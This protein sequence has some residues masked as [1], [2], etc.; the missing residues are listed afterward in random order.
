MEVLVIR[1]TLAK[2][3]WEKHLMKAEC[4]CN[5]DR[6]QQRTDGNDEIVF[7]HNLLEEHESVE[8][9]T[10]TFGQSGEILDNKTLIPV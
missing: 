8:Y 1:H 4:L 3:E 10:H 7:L 9:I 2:E 6:F 5:P